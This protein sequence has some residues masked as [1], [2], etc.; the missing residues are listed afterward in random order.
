MP[1]RRV[2]EVTT[3][4]Y[5]FHAFVI[6]LL[7]GAC[8][9]TPLAPA[10]PWRIVRAIPAPG[11]QEQL[12]LWANGSAAFLAW[13]GDLNKPDI[14][15]LDLATGG[16]PTV[17]PMGTAPRSLTLYPAPGGKLQLLWLDQTPLGDT[18][19]MG[20]FLAPDGTVERGP[21]AISSK[22]TNDYNAAVT[23]SGDLL[24]LWTEADGHST[25]LY[26]QVIDNAGRPRPP[27]RLAA[28]AAH[29]SLVYG[30]DGSL[31]VAWLELSAPRLWTIRYAVF[32]G[33]APAAVES[34]PVGVIKVE[35]NEALEDFGIGL[36]TKQV[37]CLSSILQVAGDSRARLAG[38][39]FPIGDSSAVHPLPNANPDGTS[40]RWLSMPARPARAG[41]PLQVGLTTSV[42][43]EGAWRDAPA[44]VAI[45]PD[46]IG[47][48]QPL[49][50]P[51]TGSSVIGKVAFA[52]DDG[53]SAYMAWSALRD[54][55]TAT[56]FYATNHP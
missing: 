56:I 52:L 42:Q 22:P 29:P 40:L 10:T 30:P 9:G 36:D 55:G 21:A 31:H 24:T 51:A 45:T 12:A 35:T 27:L 19:L 33:G 15:L 39:T 13:P 32:P 44:V 3:I 1:K 25:P 20:A 6:V 34:T 48:V 4:I 46:G 37:Y 41:Q 17:L 26:A 49:I 38:L 50:D 5:V 53:G 54:D 7:V 2:N 23:P 47:G 8:A 11:P 43:V 14:N 28:T 16:P 18:Y